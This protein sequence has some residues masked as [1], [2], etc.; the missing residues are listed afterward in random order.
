MY[1]RPSEDSALAL[2]DLYAPSL[3]LSPLPP[4]CTLAWPLFL[5]PAQSLFPSSWELSLTCT[6]S[7]S[8][9]PAPPHPPPLAFAHSPPSLS[10]PSLDLSFL[11]LLPSTLHSHSHQTRLPTLSA[12]DEEETVRTLLT[13]WETRTTPQSVPPSIDLPQIPPS[14][15]LWA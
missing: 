14:P 10:S 8:L 3:S 13:E 11:P 4:L 15:R 12:T 2:N 1:Q 9:L 5:V 6:A 7:L